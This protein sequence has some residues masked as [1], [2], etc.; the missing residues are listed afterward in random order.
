SSIAEL[1]TLYNKWGAANNYQH[2]TQLSITAWTLQ[3]SDDVKKGVTST[4]D[5][6]RKNPQLNKVN[7]NDNNAY[8]VCVK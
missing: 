6:V 8:A 3:T 5:L 2:Y 7:I 4:Y 1:E